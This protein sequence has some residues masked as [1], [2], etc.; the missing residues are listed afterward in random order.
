MSYN[1]FILG[2]V[3]LMVASMWS[4]QPS[5]DQ[6]GLGYLKKY[7]KYGWPGAILLLLSLFVGH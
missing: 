5:K 1:F 4:Y 6:G 3:W 2:S 7:I